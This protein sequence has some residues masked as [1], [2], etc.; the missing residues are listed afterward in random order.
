MMLMLYIGTLT[1]DA[2][3]PLTNF[4]DSKLNAEVRLAT[5]TCAI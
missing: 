1:N 3:H 4:H 5:F 2:L